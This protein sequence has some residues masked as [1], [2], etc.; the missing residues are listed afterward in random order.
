MT[1]GV[2]Q[3]LRPLTPFSC[4]Y[5]GK[6]HRAF[7]GWV[8]QQ[9]ARRTEKGAGPGRCG[10]VISRGKSILTRRI[11]QPTA[12]RALTLAARPAAP[13]TRHPPTSSECYR[14]PFRSF[15][16]PARRGRWVKLVFFHPLIFTRAGAARQD[17]CV[18]ERSCTAPGL[19]PPSV[20]AT[21]H[22]RGSSPRPGFRSV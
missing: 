14:R 15:G 10:I 11:P 19:A 1:R 12:C 9:A 6:F 7:F 17:F 3:V 5:C 13:T 18:C 22:S 16:S 21:I 4:R 20:Q 2:L 8:T